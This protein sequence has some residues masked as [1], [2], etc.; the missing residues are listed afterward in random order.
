MISAHVFLKIEEGF[1]SVRDKYSLRCVRM[2]SVCTLE[3]DQWSGVRGH[4]LC[5][6]LTLFSKRQLQTTTTSADKSYFRSSTFASASNAQRLNNYTDEVIDV[7]IVALS[8][9]MLK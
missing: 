7:S 9:N 4:C 2:T 3:Q 8:V 5:R 1:M 6:R